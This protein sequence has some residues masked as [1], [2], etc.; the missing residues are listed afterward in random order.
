MKIRSSPGV[1]QYVEALELTGKE[2]VEETA[3]EEPAA[4]E[5]GYS[6]TVILPIDT[7]RG[8]NS[9]PRDGSPPSH[10]F[11]DLRWSDQ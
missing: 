5:K 7:S 2:S 10:E 3:E 4:H 8:A 1:S 11:A 6:Q 9:T